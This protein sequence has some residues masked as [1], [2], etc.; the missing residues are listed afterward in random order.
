[1]DTVSYRRN[2]TYDP[3]LRL[4]H[5]TQVIFILCLFAT[6]LAADLFPKGVARDAIW[7][8][9]VF[10]GYG[11]AA[12]LGLRLVWG[13]VGA[14]HAR[15]SDF[16]HPAVWLRREKADGSAF[17]HDPM[18]SL[19]YLG[20][21]AVLLGMVGTGFIAAAGYFDLGPLAGQ[22]ITKEW[23]HD[24]KEIHEMAAN[25]ILAFI[26]VH[27]G[28]MIFHERRGAP[29][30]QAMVSGWQYRPVDGEAK[31]TQHTNP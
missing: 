27:V 13:I 31:V 15:W 22:G 2:K 23:A 20:L 4:I 26:L 5:W 3:L 21:Y 29:M 11:L 16:W 8:A 24:F 18:A 6:E 17:G 28:A 1:M 14:R 19:A 9:H 10:T 12:A 25:L 7:H 30:A